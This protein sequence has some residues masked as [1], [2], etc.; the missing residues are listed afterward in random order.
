M[1]TTRTDVLDKM[2]EIQVKGKPNGIGF[3]HEYLKQEHQSSSYVQALEQYHKAKKGKPVK[4]IEFVA[5]TRIG[6][7]TVKEQMLEHPVEPP[8]PKLVKES[9]SWKCHFC[10]KQGHKKP[11]C[12]KLYG[13][14]RLYQPK[15][16]VS[17]VNKE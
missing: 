7:T 2:L 5:S 3:T 16:V 4:K 1:M 17:R 10:N 12:Y 13:A 6:S 15:P 8:K 11:F 9:P 14:H